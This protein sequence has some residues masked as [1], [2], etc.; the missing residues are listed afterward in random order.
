MI[1]WGILIFGLGIKT[2]IDYLRQDLNDPKLFP[3]SAPRRYVYSKGDELVPRR[4]VEFHAQD[5]KEKGFTVAALEFFGESRHV[6]HVLLYPNRYWA[7]ADVTWRS[8]KWKRYQYVP[9]TVS[10]S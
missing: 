1:P 7:I 2:Q 10:R 9:D 8:D 6:G 4:Q 5:A 3:T